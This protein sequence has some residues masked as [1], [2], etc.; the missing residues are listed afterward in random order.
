[1][2]ISGVAAKGVIFNGSVSAYELLPPASKGRFLNAATTDSQGKFSIN[3]GAHNGGVLLE[4]NGGTYLDEATSTTLP[5]PIQPQLQLHAAVAKAAS[6]PTIAITP[7]T[8]IAYQ[9]AGSTIAPTIEAANALVN[10]LFKID[11]IGVNPVPFPNGI[12]TATNAQND[13]TWAL[14]TISQLSNNRNISIPNLIAALKADLTDGI[15]SFNNATDFVAAMNNIAASYKMVTPDALKRVGKKSF[16]LKLTVSGT[17]ALI[18]GIGPLNIFLPSTVS[19]PYDA[20]GLIPSA[21]AYPSGT[22]SGITFAGLA[23]HP[24]GNYISFG[25]AD[26]PGFPTGEIVTLNLQ[27]DAGTAVPVPTNT[28][29]SPYSI[30]NTSI[31]DSNNEPLTSISFSLALVN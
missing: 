26:F 29:N 30:T 17:A 18:A 22:A 11:C 7:F 9:L 8:E 15:L 25:I 28:I 23:Y 19:V 5:T 27:V 31:Y 3:L 20:N 10:D 21:Y 24:T 12:S 6:S 2:V 4:L 14:A 1:M 16:T 13:Y